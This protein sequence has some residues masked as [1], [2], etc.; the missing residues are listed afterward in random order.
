MQDVIEVP[1]EGMYGRDHQW[2]PKGARVDRF[3]LT[4][5]L[6]H[7]WTV[8]MFTAALLTGFWMGT[9]FETGTT[10]FNLHVASVILIGVGILVALV[11]GSTRS[12]LRSLRALFL[13][14]RRDVVGIAARLR[15]PF[16]R[17]SEVNWGKFNPGQKVLAWSLLASVIALVLTGISSWQTGGDLYAHHQVA[18]IVCLVLL[19]THVFM[20]LLNPS[21]RPALPGMLI[22]T[23]RRSWAA[24]H[25][26]GWL[27]EQERNSGAV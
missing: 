2:G 18:A 16:H 25:H 3:A 22:G 4:E 19:G 1:T 17:R 13:F 21:T 24:K 10:Q 23:V 9:E 6:L 11:F 20:A 5:R 15:D 26:S 27:A 12:V 8:A 14:D 7:W